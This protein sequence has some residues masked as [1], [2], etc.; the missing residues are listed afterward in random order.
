MGTTCEIFHSLTLYQ[1]IKRKVGWSMSEVESILS[2]SQQEALYNNGW[3]REFIGNKPDVIYNYRLELYLRRR[4]LSELPVTK[5]GSVSSK[6]D[7]IPKI[8]QT[9]INKGLEVDSNQ[10]VSFPSYGYA[11]VENETNAGLL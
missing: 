7:I 5:N 2:K 10:M 11:T 4:K 6:D 9:V 1:P 3:K 8:P